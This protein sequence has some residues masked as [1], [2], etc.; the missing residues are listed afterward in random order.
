MDKSEIF[1]FSFLMFFMLTLIPNFVDAYAVQLTFTYYMKNYPFY[2]WGGIGILAFSAL[3]FGGISYYLKEK[4]PMIM[5][6]EKLY[7]GISAVFLLV[8][9]Y[10]TFTT[11]SLS[12]FPY[13]EMNTFEYTLISILLLAPIVSLS[14]LLLIDVA[15][16]IKNR[17]ISKDS[18]PAG[19][20]LLASAFSLGCPT[21]GSILY[22][23]IGI[24]GGLSVLPFKGL[25]FK[26]IS[27]A[28]LLY[29]VNA[30]Y[31]RLAHLNPK[32]LKLKTGEEKRVLSIFEAKAQPIL[33][34]LLALSL[35][36]LAFNQMQLFEIDSSLSPSP[37]VGSSG[38]FVKVSKGTGNLKD[39]DVYSLSSTP[40]TVSAVFPELAGA[41]TED[42]VLSI[43]YPTGTPS[44]S[45]AVGG[46][47]YD[48]PVTSMEYLARYYFVVKEDIRKNNPDVWNRYLKLAAAPRGISCEFCC[49]VGPQGI[50]SQGNLRCGCK[51][52]I[53]LQA[54][55]LSLMSQTDLSD[56][57]ILREVMKWKTL[58]FPRNMVSLG[59]ELAGKDPSQIKSLPGMVGGC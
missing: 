44:Y 3:A 12:I 41:T 59:V 46:I 25:E 40:Q 9:Y 38:S 29:G 10:L 57:E 8:S 33:L 14:A 49:G 18:A 36:V 16:F 28:L 2:V 48:D 23:M 27:L 52:N 7:F 42:E 5:K 11:T 30:L 1:L 15:K 6:E 19:G 50:D 51:H 43:L 17:L 56:A 20:G 53:A 32:E 21:C 58:F 31:Q 55:T 37:T 39:V 47:T 13:I 34:L 24:S 4:F 45:D 22:S 26:I 54:L 35:P